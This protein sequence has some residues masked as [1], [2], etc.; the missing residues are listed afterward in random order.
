MGQRRLPA[1]RPPR[2]RRTGAGSGTLAG[3]M[4]HDVD[5]A[6]GKLLRTEAVAG[7]ADVVF[8]APTKEWA[9]RRNTPTIDVF[10]YDI[11]EDTSR[12]DVMVRPVYDDDGRVVERRPPP[13]RFKLSYLLTAWTRRPEDEHRL[14]SQLLAS[15]LCHDRIPEEYLGGALTDS[16]LPV[17]LQLALPAG[18]D[19][20]LTDIWSA[21]GGELKPSL[22]LVAVAP[23]DPG[24]RFPVGPPVQEPAH[25]HVRIP[26]GMGPS[27]PESSE[28]DGPAATKRRGGRRVGE[29]AGQTGRT[30]RTGKAAQTKDAQTQA[31]QHGPTAADL[32]RPFEEPAGPPVDVARGR[33]IQEL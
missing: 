23:I 15:L 4:I 20:S 29:D 7:S 14:L 31:D 18:Q 19:R 26:T 6:L 13:R 16:G 30:T 25:L 21:L 17:L 22:D 1:R 12:R 11:R 33:R 8:D 24:R 9:A 32:R 27:D 3:E 2:Q 28:S 10:L 5:A